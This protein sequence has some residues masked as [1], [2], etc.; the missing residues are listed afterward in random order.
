M[1][2]LLSVV[3]PGTDPLQRLRD[4]LSVEG[5]KS[6]MQIFNCAG[7]GALFR[8]NCIFKIQSLLIPH[9][10]II[11]IGSQLVSLLIPLPLINLL[12]VE[13]PE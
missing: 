12:F 10:C 3:G 8:V 1:G 11:L 4:N 6:Y 5:V 13:Q 2:I 7:V 9:L